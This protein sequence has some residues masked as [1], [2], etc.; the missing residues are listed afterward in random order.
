MISS[1]GIGGTTFS[2]SIRRTMPQYPM[3]STAFMTQS[4][5][6]FRLQ[7]GGQIGDKPA[8]GNDRDVTAGGALYCP[9]RSL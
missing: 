4:D 3:D 7:S 8:A 6:P 1:D 9:A 5:M 2:S